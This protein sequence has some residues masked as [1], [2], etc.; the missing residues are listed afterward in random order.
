MWVRGRTTPRKNR[1]AFPPSKKVV[2]K[3]ARGWGV[4]QKAFLIYKKK[5]IPEAKVAVP[6]RA[7]LVVP[8]RE[9]PEWEALGPSLGV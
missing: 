7:P 9:P 1:P 6:S 4:P 3:R 8:R 5:D 2:D